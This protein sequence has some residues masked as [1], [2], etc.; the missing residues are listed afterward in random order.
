[1]SMEFMSL[2]Y[3]QNVSRD[4]IIFYKNNNIISTKKKKTKKKIKQN[5]KNKVFTFFIYLL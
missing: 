5:I 3:I 2:Y 4:Y 1:M